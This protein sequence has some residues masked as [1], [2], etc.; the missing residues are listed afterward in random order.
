MIL[1]DVLATIDSLP[2]MPATALR[3]L[4]AA[5][6][7]NIDLGK[8]AA[9]IERDP[10]MTAN[11]LRLCN[12]PFYGLRKEVTSLRHAANLLGMKQVVQIALTL[13]ASGHLAGGQSGYGLSAGDLWKSS[14][15]S[16]VAA[17]LL[18]QEVLYGNPSTAYTA[19]LLQDIGKIVLAEFVGG[20][21]QEIWKAV[22]NRK[23]SFQQAEKQVV[24]MDHAEVGALLLE[25]WRF[26]AALVESV[27]NH[28][29]PEEATIDLT[30]SRISHLADALTMTMGMGLGVDGLAYVLDDRSLKALGLD[31]ADRLDELLEALVERIQQA[32]DVLRIAR[33]R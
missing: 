31:R 19:G 7:T 5:Q 28:H 32:D 4:E 13:L 9:W 27:R 2:P 26:P 10:A 3:L 23:V 6:D 8:V 16:A 21:V 17:E 18:A 12:A 25:R 33:E 14:V 30:L 15:T 20:A 29:R 24:G 22:E 11:L 1:N